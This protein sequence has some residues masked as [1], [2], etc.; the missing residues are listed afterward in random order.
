MNEVLTFGRLVV[1]PDVKTGTAGSSI[2]EKAGKH[3]VNHTGILK[4]VC[5]GIGVGVLLVSGGAYKLILWIITLIKE[6]M[7]SK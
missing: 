4:V 2:I 6:H 1:S 3:T 5:V 7:T